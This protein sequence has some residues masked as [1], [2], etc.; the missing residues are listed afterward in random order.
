MSLPVFIAAVCAYCEAAVRIPGAGMCAARC[1][2][3]VLCAVVLCRAAAVCITW[4]AQVDG[5][6]R[7]RQ[8]PLAPYVFG[9]ICVWPHSCFLQ[10]TLGRALESNTAPRRNPTPHPCNPPFT[11]T[12]HSHVP[13]HP[14]SLLSLC[15]RSWTA[16]RR[17][18][19]TE[20]PRNSAG[21]RSMQPGRS[22]QLK[23]LEASVGSTTPPC[24][25]EQHHPRPGG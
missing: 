14:P 2:M 4:F 24:R 16:L 15:R 11:P 19:A 17:K 5:G 25:E 20:L 22:A 21:K 7:E 8:L 13:F 23:Q 9:P 6:G 18:T 10:E 3:T 12:L 1:G